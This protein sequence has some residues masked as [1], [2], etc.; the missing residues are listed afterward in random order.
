MMDKGIEKIKDI[1]SRILLFVFS[2][3]KDNI[4]PNTIK[5]R[6]EYTKT[7]IFIP[8]IIGNIRHIRLTTIKTNKNIIIRVFCSIFIS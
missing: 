6:R 4:K 8:K 7:S 3:K 2:A 5:P 1:F